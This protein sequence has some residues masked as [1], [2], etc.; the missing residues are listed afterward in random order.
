VVQRGL[1]AALLLAGTAVQVRA[2][3]DA[4]RASKPEVRKQVIAVIEEQLSAFRKKD[5]SKAYTYAAA[6]LRAQTSARTFGTIVRENYPEIWTNTQ[7]EYGLV[8]DDGTHAT[9]LVQVFS[10]DGEAAFD[11]VLLKERD[12][13][14]IGS[15]MR[16][17]VK[18]KDN[19]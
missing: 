5:V 19:V 11:Y 15:V 12:G 1:I 18:R 4:F 17:E 13:W 9:I 14:R 10:A 16:H 8:R 2:A 7:A 3:S 6:P